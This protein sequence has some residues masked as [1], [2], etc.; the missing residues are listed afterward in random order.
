MVE[1]AAVV[2]AD[3]DSADDAEYVD[4]TVEPMLDVVARLAAIWT[5]ASCLA[6]FNGE[7]LRPREERGRELEALA[8]EDP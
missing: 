5:A 1:V 2:S 3:L 4:E 6:G 8:L 7:V